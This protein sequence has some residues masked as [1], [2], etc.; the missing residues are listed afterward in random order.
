MTTA[1]WLPDGATIWVPAIL[2]VIGLVG[3]V[4]PVLPGLLVIVLAVLLWAVEIG[5]TTAWVVLGGSLLL[6]AVGVTLQFL[7]PGRRLKRAGVRT[8]TLVLAVVLGIVGFFVVPVVG[9]PLGFVLGIYL[10]EQSRSHDRAA[11]WA[12]TKSALKAVL[13]SMGIELVTGLLVA[14]LWVVGVLV[15]G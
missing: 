13:H 10:V 12:S 11:A 8:P 4:V 6:Y 15:T 5:T 9:G 3:I 7:L 14:A 2:I 1:P